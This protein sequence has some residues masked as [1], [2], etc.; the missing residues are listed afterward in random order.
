[1]SY[2][3]R[4]RAV[5]GPF[6]D[7]ALRWLDEWC[8]ARLARAFAGA[9]M[10]LQLWNGLEI[11]M[12]PGPIVGSVLVRDRA[13]LRRLVMHPPEIAF[14]EAYA[15]GRLEV[16]GDLARLLE[17]I[18]RA[19]ADR[20]PGRV[21]ERPAAAAPASAR[22]NVHVHY[23]LGNDFYRLWL[24]D[25][26]V[27]TC[28]YF[29]RP[30]VSLEEAQRAKLDYVCRK[31]RLQPGDRVVDAGCGWGGLA[32]HMAKCYGAS[33]RAYNISEPQL[34][35]ARARARS[36]GL[37]HQIEFIN[38]DYRTIDGACDAFVSIGM[39]EHVGADG[40]P[41]LGRVMDRTLDRNH[42]RGLLHFIGRNV[43]RPFNQWTTKYI[44]PGAYAPTLG[45]I[46]PT[47]IDA[48]GFS[49]VDV[50]NLRQHYAKTLEHWG[51]RFEAHV[52]SIREMFGEKFIRIWRLYLASAQAGFAA[53]DLQLFQVCFARARDNTVHWTRD[54]LYATV[55]DRRH[56]A[57]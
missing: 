53:G 13:T 57:M 25:A 24:D 8:L 26:M 2:S 55:P 47:A 4:N 16:Q 1:M 51:R 29:E 37:S 42:G 48:F 46:L 39:V 28:A 44:F 54:A 18:S 20:W 49:V 17:S 12:S 50:E 23:D 15:A 11:S 35:F 52:D 43:P 21:P 30:D 22:H 7:A 27:Y 32:L 14:G 56:A 31:L 5:G 36:Q 19:L 34:E 6:R 9:P 45:E 40:Y 3:Q 38:A 33:V 41:A 10:R